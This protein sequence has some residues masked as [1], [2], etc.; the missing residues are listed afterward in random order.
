MY[1]AA[2]YVRPE[3]QHKG[4][5]TSLLT[6]GLNQFKGQ[7]DT[8]YLEVDNKNNHGIDYYKENGFEI[9]RSYP[10]NVRRNNGLSINEEIILSR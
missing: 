7:Y 8:V 1:L 4:Y 2:H 5:G 9:V 3:S 10:R 6:E